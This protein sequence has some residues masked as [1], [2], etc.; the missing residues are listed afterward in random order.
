MPVILSNPGYRAMPMHDRVAIIH[1]TETDILISELE[2]DQADGLAD[3]I[4]E[5]A[6]RA[7]R[8]E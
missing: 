1:E 8:A 5:A 2:P 4:R 7:R 6:Q 3:S